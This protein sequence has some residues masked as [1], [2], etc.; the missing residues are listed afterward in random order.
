MYFKNKMVH[1]YFLQR[2]VLRYKIINRKKK[3]SKEELKKKNREKFNFRVAKICDPFDFLIDYKR[4]K[5]N[6]FFL[7]S[8]SFRIEYYW[9]KV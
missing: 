2:E 5:R 1:L 3:H 7:L 9:S 4:P 8:L 6:S